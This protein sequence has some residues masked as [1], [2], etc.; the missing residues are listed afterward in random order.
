VID[1]GTPH[2]WGIGQGEALTQRAVDG[3]VLSCLR[4]EGLGE[5]LEAEPGH[6]APQAGAPGR[7]HGLRHTAV[8][9]LAAEGAQLNE[10]A[11]IMGWSRSTVASMAVRYAHLFPSRQEYLTSRLDAVFRQAERERSS[12]SDDILMTMREAEGRS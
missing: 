8:S 3:H 9:I 6:V 7:A 1:E 10:L 12:T 4:R 2:V 11:S 5:A